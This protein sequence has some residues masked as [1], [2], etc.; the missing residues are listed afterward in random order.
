VIPNHAAYPIDHKLQIRSTS[1][2]Y[3]PMNI[4]VRGE[5]T[6]E[7]RNNNCIPLSKSI[8]DLMPHP[9]Y[10]SVFLIHIHT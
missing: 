6:S 7:I 9:K 3:A 2:A 1:N 5:L 10:P 8:S 4:G